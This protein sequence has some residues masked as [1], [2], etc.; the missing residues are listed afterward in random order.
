[1]IV[2]NKDVSVRPIFSTPIF[3]I[4]GK[5]EEVKDL[6]DWSIGWERKDTNREHSNRGGYHSTTSKDFNLIPNIN[7]L[8]NKLNFLPE[9]TFG[10]WWI[11]IQRKG[12][13]N[14]THNHPGAD[15]SFIWYVTDNYNSLVFVNYQNE[16]MRNRL[17]AAFKNNDLFEHKFTWDCN[18]GDLLVFPSDT[19][20]YT[21]MH[22]FRT[23][24][25]S[26]SGNIL[27]Q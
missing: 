16:M 8:K 25:I 3:H 10:N 27:M 22:D 12:N 6:K 7:I 24:R 20:H 9:H 21:K 15:L 2:I 23:P 11:N 4:K 5:E 13:Y 1:M 19:L 17:H 14:V 18:A 26:I